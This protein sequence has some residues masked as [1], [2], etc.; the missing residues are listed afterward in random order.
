MAEE[1]K[2]QNNDSDKIPEKIS[3]INGLQEKKKLKF[4][5]VSLESLSG[6]LA[7]QLKKEGHEVKCYIKAKSDADVY[8]GFVEKIDDWKKYVDW[9]DIVIFDDVEFGS[10]AEKLRQTGKPVIGGSVY[11]DQLEIDREFG[12]IELKKYG[13]NILPHYN[14]SNYDEAI[15]F[16]KTNPGLYVFKPCGN[17]PSGNKGLLFLGQEEDGRDILAL[18]EKN[19]E[20]W[21][22]KAPVFQL[23]KCVSGV[24]IAVGAF[25]N[26]QEFIRPIIVNFE[27]KRLFPGDLGPFTGEMGTAVFWAKTNPIFEAT[28]AKM[29]PALAQSGYRG[30][31][32]LNCIVNGR[33]IYPLEFTSRFGYPILQIQ[34]EGITTPIGE[35]LEKLARGENFELK[36]KKGFQVGTRIM[37]P[38]Y[39]T[40]DKA[41]VETYKDLPILFKKPDNLDGIHIEDVKLIEGTWRVA[42]DSG[43]LLVVA[44][45]GTT[46]DD[47]REQVYSRIK[48]IMVPNMFYRV[49][50]GSKWSEDSDKLQTWG[51]LY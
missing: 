16:I 2:K 12:Q 47:A 31:I 26:G 15:N 28:L 14:F 23:Q 33:G 48:N 19:K 37:L 40:S 36:T 29:K 49:D 9:C 4:L 51:Y 20:V 13:I 35:W 21:Q 45:S 10:D 17:T 41:V 1:I 5:F 42:G 44:G 38:T 39:F 34:L 25:F 27:H 18:L 11:T 3:D 46:M 6:D 30:Y 7:W 24:E 8:D 43:C 50:I 22:K 32:D